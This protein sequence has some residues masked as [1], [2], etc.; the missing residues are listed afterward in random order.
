[1]MDTKLTAP[2]FQPGDE[3]ELVAGSYPG[4]LG[5]FVGL[6]ADPKWADIA[7]RDGSIRHHPVA[8]LDDAAAASARRTAAADR[9]A[10]DGA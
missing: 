1:M 10:R 2:V 9:R 4:T 6:R 5:V 3:I 7:E 8:W